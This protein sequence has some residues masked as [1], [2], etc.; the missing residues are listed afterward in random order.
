MA[1]SSLDKQLADAAELFINDPLGYVMFAFPWDTDASIQVVKLSD[2]YADRFN[3]EFGPDEW[4]CEFL[5]ALG[6]E[7]KKN[8]FDGRTAVAPVRRAIASGHGIGKSALVAWLT[9]WI[10]TTRPGANGVVTANTMPQLSSKTWAEIVKWGKKSVFASWFEFNTGRGAMKMWHKSNPEGWKVIAQTCKEE[11]SQSFAG[12]HSVSGTPFYMFDEA[13]EIPAKIFEVAE[14]GLTDGEP[15]F[16]MFGNPTRNSGDFHDAF[17]SMAHRWGTSQIDSRTVAITNKAMI[18]EW[19]DDYGEDSDFVRVRVRGVFPRAGSTQFIPTSSITLA[20]E[21][22]AKCDLRFD[23]LIF[24]VDV[25]RFGD[26]ESVVYLRKGDDGRTHPMRRYRGLDNMQLAARIAELY[27]QMRPDAIFVD[28]GGGAG[29]ID[30]LRYLRVPGVME[31]QFGG[32]ADGSPSVTGGVASYA[33]KGVEMWGHMR[34]WLEKR[35]AIPA[36]NDLQRQ[37]EG[38]QYGFALYRGKD[39]MMLEKK[40]DMKKR[41]LP[42][43][44]IADALALTFAYPVARGDGSGHEHAGVART[45]RNQAV[46]EYDPHACLADGANSW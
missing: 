33:N 34:D 7:V 19:V 4:A 23:P 5:D 20:R 39:C 15:M 38:R 8:K 14:G 31:V 16:F 17:G 28:A 25:A 12:L 1:K 35:G 29:V 10:M 11:N 30:R 37:L 27:E 44:D 18:Q 6:A 42:S 13:S 41:G 24:G 22:E 3:S 45:Q 43:P 36:D 9:N 21:R 40:E 2:K 26:D 32:S 46:T